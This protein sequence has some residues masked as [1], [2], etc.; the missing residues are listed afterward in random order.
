MFGSSGSGD[1]DRKRGLAPLRHGALAGLLA[2]AW[3]VVF[4]LVY[5][6][7]LFR[8]LAT[9]TSLSEAL[10]DVL[11]EPLLDREALTAGIDAKLAA[12][13]VFIFSVI[14]LATFAMLGVVLS[15]MLH[16]GTMRQTLLAGGLYGLTACTLL[17]FGGLQ[18]TG[19][20]P[21][22]EPGWPSVL[23]G[24]CVAGVVMMGYLKFVEAQRGAGST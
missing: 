10:P 19:V 22:S 1:G 24:N 15:M 16:A 5:D 9:P 7:L 11:T 14:H 8:P 20:E 17:F 6:L 18:V 13:R 12:V 23:L 4:F 3:I 2:G 21:S